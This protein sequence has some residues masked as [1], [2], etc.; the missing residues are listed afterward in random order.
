MIDLS[1]FV[2]GF[3]GGPVLLLPEHRSAEHRPPPSGEL[4]DEEVPGPQP[5]E[6]GK[7]QQGLVAQVQDGEHTVRPR[8]TAARIARSGSARCHKVRQLRISHLSG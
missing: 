2:P 7:S 6:V 3:H 4:E 5:P 8:R 1:S